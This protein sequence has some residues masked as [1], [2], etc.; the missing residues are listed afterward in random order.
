MSAL[1][2][3]K[4]H[5]PRG[6]HAVAVTMALCVT[7]GALQF[8]LISVLKSMERGTALSVRHAG[9]KSDAPITVPTHHTN[10]LM[11]CTG[12]SK[13]RTSIIASASDAT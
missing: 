10:E 11:P 8:A 7:F 2:A 12:S 13:P 1:E 4:L 6:L 9:I 3:P 5:R